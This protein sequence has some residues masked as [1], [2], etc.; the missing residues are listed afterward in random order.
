MIQIV[1]FPRVMVG[2][3][4]D[5]SDLANRFTGGISAFP[6]SARPAF[7]RQKN[8]RRPIATPRRAF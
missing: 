5:R 7:P 3:I 1:D 4:P 6:S 2:M 8:S